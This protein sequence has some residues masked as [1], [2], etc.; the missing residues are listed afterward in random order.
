[1]YPFVF[2]AGAVTAYFVVAALRRPRPAEILALVLW[3]AY[4]V[5][6]YYIANGTL[7]DA[8]CNIRV[9]LI[10]FWPVLALVTYFAAQTVSYPLGV[11]SLYVFCF[12][13]TAW[14]ASMYGYTAVTAIAGAI[15]L[16]AAILGVKAKLWG[17]HAVEPP[18]QD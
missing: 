1:M 3:A 6:E 14:V 13:L 16:I 18:A 9:D 10:F 2:A 8:N 11:A 7:C 15:A 12:G 5:Y 17:S 4:A